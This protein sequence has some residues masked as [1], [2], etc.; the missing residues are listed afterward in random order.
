MLNTTYRFILSLDDSYCQES[1]PK[2]FSENAFNFIVPIVMGTNNLKYFWPEGSYFDINRFDNHTQFI[3][4]FRQKS[5]N[6]KNYFEHFW[7]KGFYNF[8]EHNPFCSLCEKL[9][10]P[11]IIHYMQN[12]PNITE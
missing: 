1:V 10:E 4:D 12:Y 6:N 7:W 3:E 5:Q 11:N 9:H 8:E 2:E